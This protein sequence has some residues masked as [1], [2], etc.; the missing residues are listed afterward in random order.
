MQTPFSDISD[1]TSMSTSENDA[2]S[3]S[4][5]HTAS[6]SAH[7]IAT[8]DP[9]KIS[10]LFVLLSPLYGVFFILIIFAQSVQNSFFSANGIRVDDLT[11]ALQLLAQYAGEMHQFSVGGFTFSVPGFAVFFLVVIFIALYVGQAALTRHFLSYTFTG[12]EFVLKRGI[13][14][15]KRIHLPYIKVQSTNTKARLIQRLCGCCDLNIVTAGGKTNEQIQIPF[16]TLA[17]AKKVE[18]EFQLRKAL[19]SSSAHPVAPVRDGANA[20]QSPE[21]LQTS[22]TSANAPLSAP[23]GS[24]RSEYSNVI[25]DAFESF[26]TAGLGERLRITARAK[27][28]LALHELILSII[29]ECMGPVLILLITFACFIVIAI[30]TQTPQLFFA[31]IPYAIALWGAIYRAI[32]HRVGFTVERFDDRIRI[33]HGLFTRHTNEIDIARI[34]SL[35]CDKEFLH[36]LLGYQNISIGLITSVH[37]SIKSDSTVKHGTQI[38]FPFIKQKDIPSFLR[39]FLPEFSADAALG[40]WVCETESP[41]AASDELS[42]TTHTDTASHAAFLSQAHVIA[43]PDAH[44][45]VRAFTRKLLWRNV[46]LYLVIAFSCLVAAIITFGSTDPDL[47]VIFP[48]LIVVDGIFIGAAVL[49]MAC[50][51]FHAYK[52]FSH[53]YVY[54]TPSYIF[55]DN[56]GFWGSRVFMPRTKIQSLRFTANPF[57]Q[58]RNIATCYAS[59]AEGMKDHCVS[60]W[61]LSHDDISAIEKMFTLRKSYDSSNA[62]S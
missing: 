62:L 50:R 51:A 1:A 32:E 28:K 22:N 17:Q 36:A 44:C 8:D 14:F 13:I 11:K 49:F 54:I 58:R 16:I 20:P 61:D 56:V 59:S 33:E 23:S 2:D 31:I 34:Q 3:T 25:D 57:Q 6:Q 19:S 38:I 10:W 4:D 27:R 24:E 55:V 52:W 29:N 39:D 12:K 42:N 37:E 21:S 45:L 60:F 46:P 47:C 48:S 18:Y 35:H 40:A 9:Q 26:S 53:A 7:L 41:R 5:V 43:V 15:K 30:Q